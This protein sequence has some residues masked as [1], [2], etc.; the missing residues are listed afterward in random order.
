MMEEEKETLKN[1][2]QPNAKS[3]SRARVQS[4]AN[5]LLEMGE[6]FKVRACFWLLCFANAGIVI[7]PV[8]M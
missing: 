7:C 8:C 1:D 5:A 2:G 6:S 3:R 4:L